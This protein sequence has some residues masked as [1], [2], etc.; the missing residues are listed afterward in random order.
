MTSN[1]G[2]NPRTQDANSMQ[3][4]ELTDKDIKVTINTHIQENRV[5]Q[6]NR[7]KH[8]EVC[9]WTP[10]YKNITNVYPRNVWKKTLKNKH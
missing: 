1:Q 8:G 6:K 10:I 9:H 4:L 2:K 7:Q 3:V 5:D